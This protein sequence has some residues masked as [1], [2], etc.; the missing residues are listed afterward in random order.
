MGNII[1]GGKGPVVLFLLQ[2]KK[3]GK[4]K[5]NTGLIKIIAGFNKVKKRLKP[6]GKLYPFLLGIFKLQVG[7]WL[8]SLGLYIFWPRKRKR[9]GGGRRKG[10]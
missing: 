2:N 1:S 7:L 8:I 3:I 4:V 6:S 5:I 10:G 9:G